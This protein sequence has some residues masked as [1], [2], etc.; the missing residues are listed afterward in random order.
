MGPSDADGPTAGP[1]VFPYGSAAA[2]RTA[3]RDRFGPPLKF[4]DQRDILILAADLVE[5]HLTALA[6][7][8]GELLTVIGQD[9]LRHPNPDQRLR[10]RQA[11]RPA[12]GVLHHLA[13]T[14]NRE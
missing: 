2:F 1:P 5:Q 6:E 9:L 7:P 11:H 3:L 13:L 14:Q 12:R 4:H 10:E 8:V